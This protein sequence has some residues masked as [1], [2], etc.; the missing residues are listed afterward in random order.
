LLAF[1]DNTTSPVDY[2][3]KAH[4]TLI[5]NFSIYIFSFGEINLTQT[6]INAAKVGICAQNIM[7]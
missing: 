1:G 3:A 5:Q 2:F 4:P 7:M 6:N